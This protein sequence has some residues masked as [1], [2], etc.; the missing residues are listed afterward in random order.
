MIEILDRLKPFNA[1]LAEEREIDPVHIWPADYG[2]DPFFQ[3][4]CQHFRR[5]SGKLDCAFVGV[6][7]SNIADRDVTLIR[8]WHR[9]S[10]ITAINLSNT[11]ITDAGVPLLKVHESLTF[12]NLDQ[13]QV[14]DRGLEALTS[15]QRLRLL[16][17][18]G[19]Q[20]TNE[21]VEKL[22]KSLPHCWVNHDARTTED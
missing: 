8:S 18:R 20:V 19:T 9:E 12:L 7:D 17:V 5:T 6:E 15:L 3:A 1:R 16:S 11:K 10:P 13:T 14:T 22:Q 2:E 21:G 4:W